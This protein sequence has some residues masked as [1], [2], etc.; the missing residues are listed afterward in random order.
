M[1]EQV[2]PA[3]DDSVES[4]VLRRRNLLKKSV[5]LGVPLLLTLPGKAFANATPGS[6]GMSGNMS[7]GAPTYKY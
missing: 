3:Q 5:I 4:K 1:N 2:K 7:G 6:G